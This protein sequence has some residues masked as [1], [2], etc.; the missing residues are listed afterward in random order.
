MKAPAVLMTQCIRSRMR[1]PMYSQLVQRFAE[2][3]QFSN[4]KRNGHA[5]YK[6]LRLPN[7]VGL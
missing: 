6:T 1:S 4:V 5:Q 7:I 2:T 3:L